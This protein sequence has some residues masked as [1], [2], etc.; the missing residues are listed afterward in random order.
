MKKRVAFVGDV[1]KEWMGGLNYFKNLLFAI[2]TAK[3]EEIEIVVFVG[4]NTDIEIKKMFSAYAPVIENSLFDRKSLKW[5]IQKVEQKIFRTNYLLTRFFKKYNIQVV[6][7][8]SFFGTK[9]IK[10]INWIPDFQHI[11]LPQMFSAKEIKKRDNNFLELI[12]YSDKIVLSSDDA[13]K[14]FKAFAPDYTFKASVLQFVSQPD[15]KY[16]DIQENEKKRLFEKYNL[17]DEFYYLPNQFWKHKNHMLAFQSIKLLVDNKVNICLVCTGY[18]EDYRNSDY[19]IEIQNFVKYNQLENSIKLLG[20]V[21]YE[22]VFRLIKFSKAVI[23]PSL[24]EGW[25]STVEECKSIGKNMILS[26]L[27]VH[28][29]QYPEATFFDRNSSLSLSNVLKDY[30]KPE[31]SLG[32][33]NLEK[34]TRDFALKYIN[35]IKK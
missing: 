8:A 3:D 18:L 27:D 28:K 26:D 12:R 34:R 25:S 11:H 4:K 7:H 2:N 1:S 32:D 31:E 21:D 29:E 16:F 15:K 20:L 23:N 13:L 19:I 6:S 14:D 22:D 24:F 33:Q 10:T 30:V 17:P 9:G 35:L 5:Y